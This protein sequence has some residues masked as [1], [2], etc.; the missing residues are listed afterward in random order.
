[1]SLSS[2]TLPLSDV[3]EYAETL[4]AQRISTVSG[5][6]RVSVYGSQKYAV[7]IQLDPRLLASRGIGI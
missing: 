3:D 1:M 4:M 7:R 2:Q 6:A 5:V